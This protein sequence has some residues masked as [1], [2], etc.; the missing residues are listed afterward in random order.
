[1]HSSNLPTDAKFSGKKVAMLKK[2]EKKRQYSIRNRKHRKQ[3][4]KKKIGSDDKIKNKKMLKIIAKL[5][6]AAKKR[7]RNMRKRKAKKRKKIRNKRL[8]IQEKTS[9]TKITSQ[10]QQSRMFQGDHCQ[11]LDLGTARLRGADCADGT[12]MV[13]KSM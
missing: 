2:A 1:M 4:N 7:L 5:R 6:K 10:K 3:K 8:K 9:E 13:I 11:W 12:K